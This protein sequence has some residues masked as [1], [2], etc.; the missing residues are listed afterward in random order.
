MA[1]VIGRPAARVVPARPGD[2]T[3]NLPSA[4][5]AG[6]DFAD[7]RDDARRDG[8]RR[9]DAG[10]SDGGKSYGKK[11][12]SGSGKPYAGRRDGPPPRRDDDAPRRHDRD[13][14]RRF[15][16]DAS[17]PARFGRMTA[18]VATGPT[19]NLATG[20][21]RVVRR[22]AVRARSSAAGPIAARIVA[23]PGRGRSVMLRHPIMSAA[24]PD[25][26]T[27]RGNLTSPVTTSRGTIGVANSVHVFRV[28]ARIGRAAIAR[29]ANRPNSIA[30][31]RIA[32]NSIARAKDRRAVRAGRSIRAVTTGRSAA[33]RQ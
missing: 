21:F 6:K 23:M 17:R 27:A 24:I 10:K 31:A 18:R 13:A 30:R 20:N 8:A 28:R 7:K 12:Y 16:K 2:P 3:R 15:D 33:T 29:S 11:P 9:P 5:L 14:P 22:T 19:K 32:R 4:A 1:G 26:A 25:L